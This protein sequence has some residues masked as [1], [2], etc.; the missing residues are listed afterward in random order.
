MLKLFAASGGASIVNA[1]DT[2][3]A[4]YHTVQIGAVFFVTMVVVIV[5]AIAWACW[6]YARK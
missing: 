3:A 1:P 2:V 5:A 4:E 6:K